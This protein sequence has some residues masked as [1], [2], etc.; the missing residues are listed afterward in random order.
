M[1]LSPVADGVSGHSGRLNNQLAYMDNPHKKIAIL[2]KTS[3]GRRSLAWVLSALE[4]QFTEGTYRLYLF[5]EAPVD[6]WKTQIYDQLR[7][8]GH[9]VEVASQATSVALARNRLIDRLEDEAYVLRL[10]DDFELAGEFSIDPLLS[11]LSDSGIDFCSCVERQVGSGRLTPSGKTRIRAGFVRFGSGRYRPEVELLPDHSW[12]YQT[13]GG[14]RFAIA[15][16]MRNLIL[17]KRHCFEK[18][19]WNDELPFELEHED[20]YFSLKRAGFAGA[21]TPDSIFLHRDDLK[22]LCVDIDSEKSWRGD[23][24]SDMWI[25]TREVFDREWNG[26]PIV[27]ERRSWPVRQ[28]RNLRRMFS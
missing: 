15:D 21:F 7:S 9:V 6:S 2:I 14:V 3:P 11:V 28:I 12:R 19:R 24:T 22:R 13:R 23:Y 4:L 1:V 16:Y 5:D 10:D 27:A 20:F 17:I 25:K 18:V 8:K 26:I